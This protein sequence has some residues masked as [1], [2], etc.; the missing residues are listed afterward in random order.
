MS[1]NKVFMSGTLTRDPELKATSG[2]DSVLEFGLAVNDRVRDAGGEWVDR[3]NF[4]DCTVWG[5]RA[6]ALAKILAK[7]MKVCVEGGIRYSSWEDKKTGQRRSKLRIAV[8]ELEL[9]GRGQQQQQPDAS[10]VVK[11]AYPGATVEAY[12][13]SD[14]PF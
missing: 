5:R 9:M 4:V 13:D 14:I 2:G 3:P 10:Q 1:I 12:D 6:D 8:K 7:G 11:G